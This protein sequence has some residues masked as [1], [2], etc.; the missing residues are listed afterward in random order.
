[1]DN[2]GLNNQIVTKKLGWIRIISM[3][4]THS[5]GCQVNLVNIVLLKPCIDRSLV[6]QIQ[7]RVSGRYRNNIV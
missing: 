6:R 5:S 2:I 1:M 3:N 4:A 7:L